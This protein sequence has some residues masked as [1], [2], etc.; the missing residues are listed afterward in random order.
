MNE[1]LFNPT[2]FLFTNYYSVRLF[3]RSKCSIE[4]PN[5]IQNV[6][7]NNLYKSNNKFATKYSYVV[8]DIYILVGTTNICKLDNSFLP[9]IY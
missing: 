8:I 6:I 1:R 3:A 7:G 2:R 5:P 9:F 4:I